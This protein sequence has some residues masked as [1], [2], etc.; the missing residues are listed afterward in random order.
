M[1]EVGPAGEPEGKLGGRR[2][3]RGRT[4]GKA[5]PNHGVCAVPHRSG[6][7]D[8]RSFKGV[9]KWTGSKCMTLRISVLVV[10]VLVI[11][12]VSIV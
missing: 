8:V 7:G 4:A 5:W 9:P 11:V 6:H 1:S 2:S 12:I 3:W 10:A